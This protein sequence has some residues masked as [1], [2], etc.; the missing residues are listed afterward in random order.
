MAG[1]Y[2]TNAPHPLAEPRRSLAY[3]VEV[4]LGICAVAAL[5]LGSLLGL[6]LGWSVLAALM[7]AGA[8]LA[9]ALSARRRVDHTDE[10]DYWVSALAAEVT[11]VETAQRVQLTGE[12]AHR[13]NLS[14]RV[15]RAGRD[16]ASAVGANG[17]LAGVLTLYRALSPQ[18]LVIT[19]VAGSGKT[20][21]AT[22]LLL[23]LVDADPDGPVPVRISLTSWDT[24]TPFEEWLA[25]EVRSQLPPKVLSLRTAHRLVT[26]RHVL[27]VL[28]GLDE[29]DTGFAAPLRP[30][31][32]MA[33]EA[34]N[35][36]QDAR[37]LA[38]LIVTCRSDAYAELAAAGIR[39]R[40]AAHI[41]LESLTLGQARVYLKSRGADLRRWEPLLRLR[42][43]TESEPPLFSVLSTPWLLNLALTAYEERD[44][45]T[46][47][48]SRDPSEL[49]RFSDAN[50][51][52]DHLLSLYIPALTRQHPSAPDRYDA[53]DVHRWL[54]VLSL[55]LHG[56]TS[57]GQDGHRS[58]ILLHELWP[59]AGQRLVRSIDLILTASHA[60]VAIW[61]YFRA[62]GDQMIPYSTTF[63]LL[64]L[65][66]L[67]LVRSARNGSPAPL[68]PPKIRSWPLATRRMS[69][70]VFAKGA[71]L[72]AS[73]G[74]AY[75]SWKY[76]A[77]EY[78]L[79]ISV[80][81]AAWWG[82]T[83][84]AVGVWAWG[85]ERQES[86]GQRRLTDPWKPLV[87]E[88]VLVLAASMLA[89]LALVL[90]GGVTAAFFI[91]LC[92]LG[93]CVGRRF[94]V[95]L[96]CAWARRLLPA[97]VVVFL[98][99]ARAGGMLRQSGVAYRFRHQ[100]LQEWLARYP[101]PP[102]KGA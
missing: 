1:D 76:A 17:R 22:E 21:V 13:I 9:V 38:A 101:L 82:V 4:A 5:P 36:Y 15:V 99:W 67:L 28:D 65:T 81:G 61:L 52:R 24:T 102:N 71:T 16:D 80:V 79:L 90:F 74:F 35:L 68:V 92:Q 25:Q 31:A 3:G 44:S 84:G 42:R 43:R 18:R 2:V 88:T 91:V 56:P 47:A 45:R 34:I 75:L 8:G 57:G 26:R 50:A 64:V 85:K 97:E 78:G 6:P 37:G 7:P 55:H 60:A 93:S 94:L 51:L 40:G 95:F 83:F 32:A 33:V 73:L 49:L 86:E 69:R 39:V 27:P 11:A 98:R 87:F 89:S 12:G 29:M 23:G 96:F 58:G 66:L 63:A 72:G 48:H 46:L 77:D 30:R 14:Y 59:S 70:K 20:A 10:P 100:E 62:F 54:S 41:T 19:G 53:R